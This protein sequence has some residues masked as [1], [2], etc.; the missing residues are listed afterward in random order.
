MAEPGSCRRAVPAQ[1]RPPIA[2][3]LAR[4]VWGR[5]GEHRRRPAPHGAH[6]DRCRAGC[7]ACGRG[8]PQTPGRPR[9]HSRAP[10]STTPTPCPRIPAG[11][12]GMGAGATTRRG[13]PRP[14]WSSPTRGVAGRGRSPGAARARSGR[15]SG[16][17]RS[18]ATQATAGSANGRV[19]RASHPASGTNAWAESATRI[20]PRALAAPRFSARPKVNE[21]A[22]ATRPGERHEPARSGAFDPPI[23]SRPR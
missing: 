9:I 1:I 4:T 15:P 8:R 10:A 17:K 11:R 5:L 20:S 2:P 16:S 18:P 22:P 23:R 13:T 19:R 3:Q 14:R 7:R 21:L 12:R 6:V